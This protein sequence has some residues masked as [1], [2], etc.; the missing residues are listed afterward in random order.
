LLNKRRVPSACPT[1]R[2]LSELR[3]GER[4]ALV[5]ALT[6]YVLPVAGHEGYAKAEVTGGGVPLNQLSAATMES[7]LLPGIYVCG[8]LVDVFGRI[9]GEW[10][11]PMGGQGP[12][13]RARQPT[14]AAAPASQ[15]LPGYNFWWAWVSGRLAGL[16][17]A[18]AAAGDGER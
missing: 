13:L 14:A 17:A 11:P 10:P 5:D 6:R 15:P 3:K 7:R 16:S 18:E 2:K 4:A 12:L 9:G 1:R 8:E